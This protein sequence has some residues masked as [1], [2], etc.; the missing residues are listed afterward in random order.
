MIIA[1]RQY[2]HRCDNFSLCLLARWHEGPRGLGSSPYFRF[3]G[4]L[5]LSCWR[6]HPPAITLIR[7]YRCRDRTHEVP[8]WVP[9]C[10]GERGHFSCQSLVFR[11]RYF[12]FGMGTASCR[13]S[14]PCQDHSRAPSKIGSF[15]VMGAWQDLRVLWSCAPLSLS[16][17]PYP[18]QYHAGYNH[19]SG[20]AILRAFMQW[21]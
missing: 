11:L 5:P 4:S 12:S 20:L 2:P 9:G 14:R 1:G 17:K 8:R 18:R 16:S 10:D 19:E 7:S 6:F 3:R 13:Q 21:F 15:G